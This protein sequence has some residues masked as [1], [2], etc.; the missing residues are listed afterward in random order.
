MGQT[1]DFITKLFEGKKE[2]IGINGKCHDCEKEVNLAIIYNKDGE[3]EIHGGAIYKTNLEYPFFKCLE[4]LEKDQVLRN[5]QECEVFSRVCGYLRPVQGYNP[6][7][8]AEFKMRKN[9]VTK[10]E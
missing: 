3:I 7:K 2:P 8:Q 1:L 6:G 9:Y 4:C 5:Y 10:G